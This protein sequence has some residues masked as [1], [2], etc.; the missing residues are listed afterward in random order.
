[1]KNIRLILLL[2]ALCPIFSCDTER[3]ITKTDGLSTRSGLLDYKMIAGN[4]YVVLLKSIGSSSDP[5]FVLFTQTQQ[6]LQQN[7]QV[8]SIREVFNGLIIELGSGNAIRWSVGPD[9]TANYSG[10]GLTKVSGTQVYP[11]FYGNGGPLPDPDVAEVSC[12]CKV[13][14]DKSNCDHGGKGSTECSIEHGGTLVGSG[15]QM[16]CTVKCEI[17]Y[18]ACCKNI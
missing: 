11:L 16:K 1:M 14:N 17:G 3:E 8:Q 6:N 15:I 7:L 4:G 12:K 18:Y 10:Y 5:I 13:N 9:S 2:A